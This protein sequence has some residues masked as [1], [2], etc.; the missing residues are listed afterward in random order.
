MF[1]IV[2]C[3][4][5]V[6]ITRGIICFLRKIIGIGD[7]KDSEFICIKKIS[8]SAEEFE[9]GRR[10]SVFQSKRIKI[11]IRNHFFAFF[12]KNLGV[13]IRLIMRKINAGYY[14]DFVFVLI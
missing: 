6:N 9:S 10:I 13:F 12:I 5:S 7:I 1:W 14:G 4:K 11:K 3:K 8:Q 2:F